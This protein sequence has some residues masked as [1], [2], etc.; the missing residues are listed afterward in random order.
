MPVYGAH[1]QFK[2]GTKAGTYSISP[3]FCIEA[4]DIESARSSI[5]EHEKFKHDLV[6]KIL[7]FSD[8]IRDDKKLMN[9]ASREWKV[10][11]DVWIRLNEY[12][13]NEP[14]VEGIIKDIKVENNNVTYMIWVTGPYASWRAKSQNDMFRCQQYSDTLPKIHEPRE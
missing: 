8:S 4:D 1:K 11:D 9:S 3:A 2:C 14:Y 7:P 6:Y 10:N 13:E 12:K 5:I